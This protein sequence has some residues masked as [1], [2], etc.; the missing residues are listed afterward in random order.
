MEHGH[1]S[2]LLH[3]SID[4]LAIVPG[5]VYVDGTLGSGGHAE[6][7]A[8]RFGTSVRIIG[9]DMD[10]DALARSRSRLEI[11][12]AQADYVQGN[13][14]NIDSI[15]ET[16]GITSVNRVLL[17]IGLSSNQLEESG[18]GFSFMRDEPLQMTFAK[19]VVEGDTT[20][21]TVVNE[22][23]EETLATI[24]Y[25]FGEERYSRRIAKAIVEARKIE[26]ITTTGQLVE[27]IASAV[28]AG[29]KKGK[30]HFATRTFQAIR[31]AVNQELQALTEGL[32][33][34]F[35]LLAFGGR[36]A[37]ISFHSLEDRIV[38]NFF[39]ALA[40]DGK[41]ILITK[42]PLEAGD[43]EQATNRRSRSAKLRIIEKQKND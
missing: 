24:I 4:G 1:T 19:D 23:S 33:K 32:Q 3:E 2:V 15:L 28:P 10:A 9:I 41:G 18:R 11:V 14:R 7:V 13:F 36:L 16:L 30:I 17:D 29:Y 6:E 27:V 42:K 22:W 12:G 26:P 37:V 20:A 8:K 21:E 43:E 35:D 34:S 40:Q 38:K 39:R 25:G 5:D 31:I